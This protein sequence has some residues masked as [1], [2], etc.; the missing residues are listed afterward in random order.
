MRFY[1]LFYLGSGVIDSYEYSV[2]SLSFTTTIKF[3]GLSLFIGSFP[4]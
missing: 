1:F 3:I 2:R 4:E